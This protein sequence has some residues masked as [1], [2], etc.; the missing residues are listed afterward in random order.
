RAPLRSGVSVPYSAEFRD[1]ETNL[2]LLNELAQL[3]PAGG[4]PGVMVE[5]LAQAAAA[6]TPADN[7][8]R[9]DLAKARSAQQIWPLL[10]FVC[11]CLFLCDVGVRRVQISFAW[12]AP[13]LASVR[14]RVLRRQRVEQAV[15][16]MARLRSLK[17]EVSETIERRRSAARFEASPEA[18][19]DSTTAAAMLDEQAVHV[20]TSQ[21]AATNESLTPQAAPEDNSYTSRLL[22]AKKKVWEGKQH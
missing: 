6:E 8:F 2:T 19:T 18:A 7:S 14:D 15:P 3:P 21:T 11:G 5:N 20:E 1:K 12:L 10:L 9:H 17:A 13:V 22:K 16:T 4:A